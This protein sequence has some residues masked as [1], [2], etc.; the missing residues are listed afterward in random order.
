MKIAIIGIGKMGL[1]HAKT[2]EKH[3]ECELVGFLDLSQK[4]IDEALKLYP[5]KVQ[6]KSVDQ[7]STMCDAVIISVPTSIHSEYLAQC[8]MANINV[9]CEKASVSSLDDYHY[10]SQLIESLKYNK[11]INI[12]HVERFNPAVESFKKLHID[13]KNMYAKFYRFSN[14]KRNEDVSCIYDTM[15]HDI[16][17]ALYLFPNLGELKRTYIKNIKENEDYTYAVN[18]GC[19]FENGTIFFKVN[20]RSENTKRE[21]FYTNGLNDY[22]FFLDEKN[23]THN[24]KFNICEP[25]E[26]DQ[27]TKQLDA[28]LDACNGKENKGVSFIENKKVIEIANSIEVEIEICYKFLESSEYIANTENI[29]FYNS[30][31]NDNA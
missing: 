5:D 26:K 16:D 21:L 23:Y 28:F 31:N 20:K 4:A 9:L 1:N 27:L 12:G 30:L 7:I 29:N 13:D 8:V 6:F 14:T 15:V 18:C 22:R 11:V 2:I 10:V 19:V 3:S 17:L 24:N 25:S